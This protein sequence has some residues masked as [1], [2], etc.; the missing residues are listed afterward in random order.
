[1]ANKIKLIVGPGAEPWAPG[2][3]SLGRLT[4]AM[5]TPVRVEILHRREARRRWRLDHPQGAPYPGDYAYRAYTRGSRVL[6]LVDNTE[7]RD[8]VIWLLVHELAHVAVDN[9]A[10]L[11]S[12]FRSIPRPP[13]YP[14]DDDAHGQVPEERLANLIADQWGPILGYTPGLDR[15]WW[16]RRVEAVR[17]RYHPG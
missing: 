9:S 3:R 8:S 11:K 2:P 7:T 4:S 15:K 14:A 6:L 5:R 1:M 17:P 16:R 13:G 12:A 10:L